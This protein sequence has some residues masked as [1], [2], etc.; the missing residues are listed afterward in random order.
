M[1]KELSK[2]AH[3]E[4]ELKWQRNRNS[5]PHHSRRWESPPRGRA[6]ILRDMEIANMLSQVQNTSGVGKKNT[7]FEAAENFKLGVSQGWF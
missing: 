5:Y 7:Q 1:D 6:D 4:K 3:K 2:P